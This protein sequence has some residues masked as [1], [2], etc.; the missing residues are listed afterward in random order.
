LK[1]CCIWSRARARTLALPIG[2]RAI[3]ANGERAREIWLDWPEL[4]QYLFSVNTV[5]QLQ[6]AKNRLSELVERA[7]T[8][9]AQ[10]ITKHGRPVVVVISAQEYEKLTHPREKLVDILRRCPL[11]G[12]VVEKTRGL[13]RKTDLG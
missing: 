9:G 5:W 10:V 8:K 13:A 2:H 1:I 7:V 4:P 6:E 12:F 11:P 3:D